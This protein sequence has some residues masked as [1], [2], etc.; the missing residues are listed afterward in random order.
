MASIKAVLL[1]LGKN[2][3]DSYSVLPNGWQMYNSDSP[4]GR[5]V[6]ILAKGRNWYAANP[7]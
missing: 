1:I 2:L 7:R 4:W 6:S 3:E 5:E